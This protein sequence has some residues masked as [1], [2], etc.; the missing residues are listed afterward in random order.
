MK[1][2]L[3]A[4]IADLGYAYKSDS[5][6]GRTEVFAKYMKEH[7]AQE[8]LTETLDMIRALQ[9]NARIRGDLASTIAHYVIQHA[10]QYIDSG[11]TSVLGE[12][13]T[14]L[15][16]TLKAL[17]SEC[18]PRFL[19]A[20]F[21]ELITTVFPTSTIT[22]IQSPLTLSQKQRKAIRASLSEKYPEAFPTFSVDKSLLGGIRLFINGKLIDRSWQHTVHHL[23][24]SLSI[25]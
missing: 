15:I 11:D 3:L 22:V 23:L 10:G 5:D 1:D 12:A 13:N 25:S 9:T 8:F 14:V 16:K 18:T 17:R 4:A 2:I 21:Q 19:E 20:R 6:A 7:S 24:Q